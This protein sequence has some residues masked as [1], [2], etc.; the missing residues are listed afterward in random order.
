MAVYRIKRFSKLQDEY[1]INQKKSDAISDYHSERRRGMMKGALIGQAIAG[2]AGGLGGFLGGAIGGSIRGRKVSQRD[3]QKI[4]EY[5]NAS[6][7]D[8]KFLM[9]ERRH[10]EQLAAINGTSRSI[11]NQTRLNLLLGGYRRH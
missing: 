4:K 3:L 10:R 9:D 6:E 7:E 8:K 11:I 2:N 1:Y 5:E